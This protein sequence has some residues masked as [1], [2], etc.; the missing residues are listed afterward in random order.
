VVS[1]MPNWIPAEKDGKKVDAEMV[2]PVAFA[3]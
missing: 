1:S 2:L 3:L